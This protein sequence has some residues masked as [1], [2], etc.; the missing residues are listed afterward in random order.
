M[1]PNMQTDVSLIKL[2]MQILLVAV[3]MLSRG[4][5]IVEGN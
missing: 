2:Y 1:I 5:E 3:A 4:W